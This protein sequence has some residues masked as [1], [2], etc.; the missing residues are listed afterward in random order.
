MT[1]IRSSGY[2]S[3]GEYYAT[4]DDSGD[5][6]MARV[7][8]ADVFDPKEVSVMHCINKCVRNC[9]LCGVDTNT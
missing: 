7:A 8:R 3:D 9:F 6:V 1:I 4:L 2:C 5:M